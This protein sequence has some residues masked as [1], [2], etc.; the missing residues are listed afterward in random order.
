MGG[1]KGDVHEYK[2][3]VSKMNVPV[4]RWAWMGPDLVWR[5]PRTTRYSMS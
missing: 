3:D 1:G 4:M 2:T 5:K